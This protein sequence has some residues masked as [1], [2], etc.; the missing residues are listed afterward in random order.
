MRNLLQ[1]V[2]DNKKF[3]E[4][5]ALVGLIPVIVKLASLNYLV[6]RNDEDF[7]FKVRLEAAKF[8]QQSCKTS[9]LTLQMFI[10]CGGLP[11]LIDFLTENTFKN[12]TA[13]ESTELQRIAL[14]GVFSVFTLQVY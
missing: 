6:N 3:L 8:V 11:I 4:N 12:Q 2:V 1:I 14:D 5:L 9:S 10:A 7:S 13:E